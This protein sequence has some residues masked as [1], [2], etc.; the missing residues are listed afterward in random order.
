ME[1]NEI[2]LADKKKE[3]KIT[4]FLWFN[5]NA[6][7]AVNFYTSLFGNS[8][9]N[10]VTRYGE[11]GA[12]MT[13]RPNGSVMTLDFHLEGQAF[14]AINGGPVFEINPAIS[15]FVNCGTT[16][17]ID[18]LW[19]RL[20]DRGTVMMELDKYPFSERYGWIQDKFGVSW[21]LI[22]QERK[23]KIA[24]CLMFA[25]DQHK[26]AE[27]A[28]NFY[29]S[30]FGNAALPTGRSEIIQLEHY[31]AGEGPEGAVVHAR[32]IL[33]GAE[34]VAMDSHMQQ[35]INFNPAVSMV[36]NCETQEE[37]D[38][39]WDS[40][41]E[42]G[43]I[44]A[45]QCGWLVDKYGVSWQIVPSILGQLMSDPEKSQRVMQALLPMKKLNIETLINA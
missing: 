12:K 36:V 10:K 34:F 2:T 38:Y 41:T 25:G 3:T 37:L 26:R 32:F 7:E 42:G 8:S 11:D 19:E 24:P 21:Q 43:D 33:A 28:V 16:R 14:A 15:F 30:V 44:S 27:E 6:E 5:D 22:L 29:I 1:T 18:I 13:G 39:Y 23:Q 40:L 4:P 35:P 45:Q 9:I 20:A 31:K 17:E